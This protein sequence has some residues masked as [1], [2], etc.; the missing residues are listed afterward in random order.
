MESDWFSCNNSLLIG[1]KPGVVSFRVTLCTSSTTG[2]NGA[3]RED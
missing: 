1:G 3:T 2:G